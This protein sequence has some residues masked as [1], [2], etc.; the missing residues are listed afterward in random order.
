MGLKEGEIDRRLREGESR[1]EREKK[2]DCRWKRVRL[3]EHGATR[4]PYVAALHGGGLNTDTSAPSSKPG[5]QQH[6]VRYGNPP[7][8][9]NDTRPP[10]SPTLKGFTRVDA[11]DAL[12]DL[13]EPRGGVLGSPMWSTPTSLVLDK[14]IIR[15]LERKVLEKKKQAPWL[16]KR[17]KQQC[18]CIEGPY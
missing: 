11:A 14:C 8:L 6:S 9:M 7:A 1:G 3:C 4:S 2:R 12:T 10:F 5:R 16:K 15:P 13:K 17:P 18:D